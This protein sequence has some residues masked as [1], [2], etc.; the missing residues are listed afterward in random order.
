MTDKTK[1]AEDDG[2]ELIPVETPLDDATGEGVGGNAAEDEGDERIAE[3]DDDLDADT[4]SG[5]DGAEGGDENTARKRRLK[6]RQHQRA[7]RERTEAELRMLREQNVLLQQQVTQIAGQT[8]QTQAGALEKRYQEVQSDIRMAES[9]MAKAIEAN[10]GEDVVAAQRI[11][12]EAIAEAQRIAAQ[13][14]HLT[15]QQKSAATPAATYAQQWT[16]AN[17]WFD[18]QARDADSQLAR[19]IDNDMAASGWNPNTR[20]YWTELTARC[21]E[22][23]EQAESGDDDGEPA[24]AKSPRRKAPPTGQ[25]REHVPSSTR[26]EIYVTPERKQAMIEAGAWEDPVKRQRMLKR[27]REYD[28]TSAR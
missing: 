22:A 18:P 11:R 8:G 3:S 4:E 5:G 23:F 17:D 16:A 20:E 12:D 24:A 6:R 25:S 10:A 13:H 1:L 9:I 2:D 15:T 26:K 7:A 28:Q 27:Y 21:K 14:Q 19:Q